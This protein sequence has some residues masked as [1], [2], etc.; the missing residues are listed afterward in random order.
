MASWSEFVQGHPL[1]RRL[2]WWGCLALVGLSIGIAAYLVGKS[3]GP[4]VDAARVAGANAGRIKGAEIGTQMGYA[5][6]YRHARRL[7]FERVYPKAYKDA[8]R[9]AFDVAG[10]EIPAATEI[11]VP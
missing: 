2:V 4:D 11:E 3:T 9:A 1:N 7:A 10:L 8:Y 6:G 5:R